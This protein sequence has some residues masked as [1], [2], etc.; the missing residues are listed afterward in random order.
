ME[1]ARKARSAGTADALAQGIS[2]IDRALAVRG[3]DVAR[4]RSER[5][6]LLALAWLWQREG[7]PPAVG[8]AS[9][10][11][12][13]A[14]RAAS[15]AIALSRGE[16]PEADRLLAKRP[17]ASQDRAI[18][19]VLRA[20][21][22]WAQGHVDVARRELDS[23][24][25]LAR[26]LSAALVLRG[27]IDSAQGYF[28]RAEESYRRALEA[29]PGHRLAALGL[30]ALV[31][32]RDPKSPELRTL[33]EA[34][35]ERPLPSAWRKVL[36]S[37][38]RWVAGEASARREMSMAVAAAPAQR[39]LLIVATRALIDSCALGAADGTI[40]RLREQGA[41]GAAFDP[42]LKL[43]RG[44]L[45]LARGLD[46]VALKDLSPSGSPYERR[47]RVWA[48]LLRGRLER[49]RSLLG[50]ERSAAAEPLRV[51]ADG[52]HLIARAQA[53]PQSREKLEEALKKRVLEPLKV[54]AGKRPRAWFFRAV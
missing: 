33:L 11:T 46:G 26:K 24:L 21:A 44:E 52:L 15:A 42:V 32:R 38:Q 8:H 31:L 36:L 49:A 2:K 20:S 1:F 40:R 25:L 47:K 14:S 51:F 22:A 39:D 53:D 45:A 48:L 29:H 37:R 13:W 41:P 23:A 5:D 43:L 18:H 30:A 4:L 7:K 27:H 12:V 16:G 34:G 10:K 54:L 17:E 28:G 6:L 35:K 50:H 3:V 19:A 9:L